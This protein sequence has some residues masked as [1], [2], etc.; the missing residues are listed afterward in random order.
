VLAD[1]GALRSVVDISRHGRA[2]I[3]SESIPLPRIGG[4]LTSDD[5]VVAG[6]RS[7]SSCNSNLIES[8]ND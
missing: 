4:N 5:A 1:G 7:Y 3:L 8:A 6:A 2:G